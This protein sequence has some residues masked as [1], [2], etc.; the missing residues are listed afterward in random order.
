MQLQLHATTVHL[1]VV[2]KATAA[3][4]ATIPKAELQ[5]PSGP[6][7]GSLCQ[8]C[9]TTTRTSYSCLTI[10]KIDMSKR[11]QVHHLLNIV[12]PVACLFVFECKLA[13]PQ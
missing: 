10:G 2:G 12:N 6:S 7:G 11:P 13:D 5:P 1:S 4:I 8:P 9:V 3:T